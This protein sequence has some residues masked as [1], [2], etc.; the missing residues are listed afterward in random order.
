MCQYKSNVLI[1]N[2]STG[3][4][5][6]RTASTNQTYSRTVFLFVFF[7]NLLTYLTIIV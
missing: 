4:I 3:V 6:L 7:K 2:R 1:L 5:T